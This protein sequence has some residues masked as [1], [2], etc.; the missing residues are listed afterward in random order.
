MTMPNKPL[1]AWTAEEVALVAQRLEQDEY[2]EV[3]LSL[4]DW[5]LLKCLQ[6]VRPELVVPYLHLLELEEDED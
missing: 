5:H 1:E 6:Y 2:P 4:E 3:T